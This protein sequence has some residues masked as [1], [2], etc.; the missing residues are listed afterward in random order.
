MWAS[1]VSGREERARRSVKRKERGGRRARLWFERAGGW[2]AG[3]GSRLRA[4][5]ARAEGEK[6]GQGKKRS[7]PGKERSWAG[8][9][10]SLFFFSIL[11]SKALSNPF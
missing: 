5:W 11:F 7:G 2:A 6:G 10:V 3:K 8:W 1:A 9:G 4:F